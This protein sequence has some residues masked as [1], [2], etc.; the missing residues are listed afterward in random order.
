MEQERTS[1]NKGPQEERNRT[2]AERENPTPERSRE[3]KPRAPGSR[4]VAP[5]YEDRPGMGEDEGES[6]AKTPAQEPGDS[7]SREDKDG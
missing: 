2:E 6:G 3:P 4:H 5:G 1:G 7:A